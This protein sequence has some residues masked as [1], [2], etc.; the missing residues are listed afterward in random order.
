MSEKRKDKKG[1]LLRRGEAQRSDGMYMYRY[2]D[3]DGV[4]RTIYSWKLVETDKLPPNKKPCVSLREQ[5]QKLERDLID[6]VKTFQVAKTTVNDI[7]DQFISTKQGVKASTYSSYCDIY[8][9]HVRTGFGTK[10]I[11]SVRYSDVKKFYMSLHDEARLKPGSIR[12]I[13]AILNSV[14]LLALRDGYIK[15]NP[16]SQVYNELKKQNAWEQEKQHSLTVPQQI[17]LMQFINDSHI[18]R[19][20]RNIVTI[21]LGTG[22]RVG[23]IAGLTWSDCDFSENL[24]SINHNLIMC[25]GKDGSPPR[26]SIST[27]K[28]KSGN[29]TIPML[30]DVRKALLNERLLQTIKRVEPQTIDG[31]ADFVFR[32]RNGN[33][34]NPTDISKAIV[35]IIDA[36]NHQEKQK[37]ES[38][39]RDPILLPHFT[40]HNL[41]HT[42]CTRLC[43]NETNL[44]V[45]QEIMGHSSI[46]ITMDV[47]NETT[48][49]QKMASF[50]HLEGKVLVQ[51][52]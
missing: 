31:Y 23:E 25:K 4:R 1:R 29:R 17:T 21:L 6:G 19:K 13:N 3:I 37:A 40:A 27:P 36:Y 8:R 15:S 50:S 16:V 49:D 43:E 35:R 45:I 12:L 14:F 5:E 46:S 44:K 22:C 39:S 20:W 51:K 52:T 10:K 11:T 28:S 48:K 42:F 24:I 38:E 26:Y 30:K 32:N 41:R 34:F 47:Y 2:N 7:F 18:Y 33:A 9:R